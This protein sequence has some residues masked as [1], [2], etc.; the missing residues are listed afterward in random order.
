MKRILLFEEWSATLYIMLNFVSVTKISNE[1]NAQCSTQVEPDKTMIS[2]IRIWKQTTT[3]SDVADSRETFR[4]EQRKH[5]TQFFFVS[6]QEIIFLEN[7]LKFEL[8]F[9]YIHRIPNVWTILIKTKLNEWNV[10]FVFFS[11]TKLIG[12]VF[13]SVGW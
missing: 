1:K 2:Y 12:V 6:C 10:L 4:F 7:N 3:C 13:V 5:L 11:S 9:D 8:K